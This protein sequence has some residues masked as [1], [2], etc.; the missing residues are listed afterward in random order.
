MNLTIKS[1][2]IAAIVAGTA[3]FTIPASAQQGIEWTP[4]MCA[5]EWDKVDA[6]RDGQLDANEAKPYSKVQSNVDV[7][8]DGMISADEYT[9]ACKGGVFKDMQRQG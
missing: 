4:E 1:T 5:T 7:D 3:V 6:N 2:A 8:K 9:V